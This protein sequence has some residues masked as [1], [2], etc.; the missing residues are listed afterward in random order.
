MQTT[1]WEIHYTWCTRQARDTEATMFMLYQGH[2]FFSAASLA[3]Q[4]YERV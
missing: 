1:L 3:L 4:I 2:R